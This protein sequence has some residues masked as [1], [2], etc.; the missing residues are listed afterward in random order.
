MMRLETA[1]ENKAKHGYH[2][3][4]TPKGREAVKACLASIKREED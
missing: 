4:C 3:A 1:G 2:V